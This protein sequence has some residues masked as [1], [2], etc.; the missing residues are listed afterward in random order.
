MI[1]RGRSPRENKLEPKGEDFTSL[2]SPLF[3]CVMVSW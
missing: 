1:N 2:S 3:E